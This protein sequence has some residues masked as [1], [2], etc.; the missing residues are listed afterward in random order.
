MRNGYGAIKHQKKVLSAH[1]VA[2]VIA[3]RMDVPEG[4]VICHTCDNRQCC[5]PSHLYA[6]TAADNVRDADDRLGDYRSRGEG[7]YNSVL[8]DDIVKLIMSIRIVLGWGSRRIGRSLHLNEWTVR[9][10]V[11]RR[12]W[13]H[14]SAPSIDDAKQIVLA[15]KESK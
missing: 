5:N 12:S 14:V 4:K 8:S 13:E 10:V 7:C 15:W 3:N 1:V 9:S 11:R 6:G 2:W